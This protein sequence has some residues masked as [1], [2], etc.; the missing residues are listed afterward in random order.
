MT[1]ALPTGPATGGA[2]TDRSSP[3]RPSPDRPSPDRPREADL[4]DVV[5]VGGGPAGLAAAVAL[6]R[7]LRRVT[8]VD[9]GEPRNAP[10]AGAHNLLGREGVPP[11]LLLADGRREAEGY[12]AVV[13]DDRVVAAR[14]AA[15]DRPE[16]PRF[17]VDL[18]SG[19]TLRARRVLL[20][21]GLVDELPDVP[22]VA[23][24]WGGAVLH[25]PYCHGWE[26]RGRRVAVLATSA[27]AV[28]VALLLR[29]LT[30]DVTLLTHTA[31]DLDADAWEA[32]AARDVAVVDGPV[33]R[34]RSESGVLRA[35]VLAGGREV[36]VD[37]VAVAPRFVA[38]GGLYTALGG[39][40]V[41]HPMG[42][43]VV[44]ADP[45]GRTPVPGVWAAGN[46]DDLAA[47]VAVAAG[48]GLLAG[49]GLNGDLVTED[50]AAA[51]AARRG[52][53]VPAR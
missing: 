20:A 30:P 34:L 12:G 31:P 25:C 32:L 7:S 26:V 42:A 48:A 27:R 28:H 49:A 50:V 53:A 33:E 22:G 4:L 2:P 21:T 52:T 18:A 19:R 43:P 38:R 8:V 24:H 11:R 39:T 35:V 6:A 13:L 10:A 17:V 44:P 40:L 16:A 45:T 9:A 5:V 14:R 23:E 46:V 37:A 3:D 15:D 36:A 29:Q 51:V 1:T 47:M 41:E